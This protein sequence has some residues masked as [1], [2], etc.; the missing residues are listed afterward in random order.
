MQNM[1]H[2]RCAKLAPNRIGFLPKP[3][4]AKEE[5]ADFMR[6]C[7]EAYPGAAARP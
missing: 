7:A 6:S 4:A 1:M 2:L 3:T 5:W